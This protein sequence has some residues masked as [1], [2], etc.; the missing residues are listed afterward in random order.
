M[1][2]FRALVPRSDRAA[3]RK[4]PTA[5]SSPRGTRCRGAGRNG[6]W[7]AGIATALNPTGAIRRSVNV[8]SS[9][10]RGFFLSALGGFVLLSSRAW[11]RID[12]LLQPQDLERIE[13]GPGKSI[14]LLEGAK[15]GYESLSLILSESAPG[16]GLPLHTHDCEEVHSVDAGRGA[17]A[18]GDERFTLDGPFV[19]RI[20]AKMPHAF[21]NAS[22][23]NLKITAAFGSPNYT[24]NSSARIRSGQTRK[25]K[26]SADPNPR[27]RGFDSRDPRGRLTARAPASSRDA[28]GRR[29]DSDRRPAGVRHRRASP[30]RAHHPANDSGACGRR[31]RD[32]RRASVSISSAVASGNAVDPGL[33]VRRL[34]R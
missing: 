34:L 13:A 20:P 33:R 22:R 4:K 29:A 15:H 26:R 14:P 11:A 27:R 2:L 19:L 31:Y 7:A 23:A 8:T 9:S 25:R 10:R 21:V 17:Y 30:H 32:V 5:R 3:A 1:P 18:I 12:R 6:E 16:G 28:T 24:F